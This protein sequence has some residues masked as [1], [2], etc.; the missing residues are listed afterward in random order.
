MKS[1]GEVFKQTEINFF[2]YDWEWSK[3][4]FLI[5]NALPIYDLKGGEHFQ[6]DILHL[7]WNDFLGVQG[8]KKETKTKK[9]QKW[10]KENPKQ[11]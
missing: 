11:N 2:I 4:D 8:S 7:F 1:D 9:S 10:K 3:E 5:Q 6:N